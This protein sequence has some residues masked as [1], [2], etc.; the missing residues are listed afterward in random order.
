MRNHNMEKYQ[1]LYILSKDVLREEINRYRSLDE[2]ASKYLAALTILLGIYG[3]FISMVLKFI[4]PPNH[5][6]D[7]FF[8]VFIALV[9]SSIVISWFIILEVLRIAYLA[10]TP[11]NIDFFDNNKL[12]DIYYATAKTNHNALTENRKTNKRKSR[13]LYYGYN[14]MR[15]TMFFL[16][17]FFAVFPLYACT[18]YKSNNNNIYNTR[19]L[20][21][22]DNQ[23]QESKPQDSQPTEVEPD[24]TIEPLPP[25]FVTEGAKPLD[26]VTKGAKPHIEIRANKE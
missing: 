22:P 8:L 7:W 23:D 13:F 6:F 14:S 12:I 26:I 1:E 24:T 15:L 25:D 21:M 5:F 18:K 10:T 9:L 17:L 20:A 16:V 2:K 19:R 3:L 4:F 11:L